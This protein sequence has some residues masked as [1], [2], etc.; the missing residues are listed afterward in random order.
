MNKIAVFTGCDL[1]L[2]PVSCNASGRVRDRT[3]ASQKK[4][5]AGLDIFNE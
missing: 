1:R 4:K 2:V 3:H 5:L